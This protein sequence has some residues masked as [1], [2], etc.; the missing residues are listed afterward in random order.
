MAFLIT[1]PGPFR[2]TVRC[3]RASLVVL[4]IVLAT[5]C[6]KEVDEADTDPG[7]EPPSCEN[8][9][10]DC[11]ETDLVCDDLDID[12]TEA[13][14]TFTAYAVS[15]AGDV[16]GDCY[17]DVIIGNYRNERARVYLGGSGGIDTDTY[18]RLG[19][20]GGWAESHF[21]MSV[22]SAGDV[23]GDGFDDVIVGASVSNSYDSESGSFPEEPGSAYVYLGSCA[24]VDPATK[25]RVQASD[26]GGVTDYFGDSVASAGDVN[27]D[28]Y[29]DVIV[30]APLDLWAKNM[31][32][33]FGSAY[34]YLGSADGVDSS[35]ETKLVGA[36]TY[37]DAFGD[38]V[39]S[40][41]D[42]NGDGYDDVIVGAPED[43]AAYVFLSG[44]DGT[45]AD[46]ATRL[47]AGDETDCF[48]NSVA[49]A[50]DVDG[51]GY[52]DVIAGIHD[53]YG[54]PAAAWVFQGSGD[55]VD[56]SAA[57]MM[58]FRDPEASQHDNFAVSVS[59]AGDVDRD[60]Y[61]DVNVVVYGDGDGG[62]FARVY[63]GGS[64]GI[65]NTTWLDLSAPG[66]ERHGELGSSIA[67]AGNVD[68]DGCYNDVIVGAPERG[69]AWVFYNPGLNRQAQP[70]Q[71]PVRP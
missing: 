11:D 57:T 34:V 26:G 30:G 66:G 39:A 67:G 22:S 13:R 35:T 40:A 9:A 27:G 47:S 16:N 55:G 28:G 29:D 43:G 14:I 70:D 68:G 31:S 24:G 65:D 7:E 3:S 18:T 54:G 19:A 17:D 62:S 37:H 15:G 20:P 52:D 63:L 10:L 41:G 38:S 51:D 33:D 48:G 50:G 56:A 71:K 61:D 12:R 42:V 5:G 4:V 6:G 53:Y 46:T 8:E 59:G 32:V 49:G 58:D 44:G 69:A 2:G 25:R 21:G 1:A 45:W 60:G 36:M 23:N 64:G